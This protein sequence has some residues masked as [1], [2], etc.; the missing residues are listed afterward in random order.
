MLQFVC[1]PALENLLTTSKEGVKC[2][3]LP[4]N[5]V[6]ISDF[7]PKASQPIHAGLLEATKYRLTHPTHFI[8]FA[9]FF[10]KEKLLPFDTFGIL[11]LTGTEFIRLPFY[12]D[13]FFI[14][15]LEKQKTEFNL[16]RAEWETFAIRACKALLKEKLSVLKHGG[17]LDLV[18]KLTLKIRLEAQNCLFYGQDIKVLRECLRTSIELYKKI[19]EIDELIELSNVSKNLPDEYLQIVAKFVEGLYYLESLANEPEINVF[20]LI[21]YIDKLNATSN[22]I[23][24]L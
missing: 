18:N 2:V 24:T 8:F 17:K 11:T 4:N 9:S 16:S 15:L 1:H 21:S 19:D 12:N 5:A 14:T 10:P 20:S 23:L 13:Q 3:T 6:I 7:L 22:K